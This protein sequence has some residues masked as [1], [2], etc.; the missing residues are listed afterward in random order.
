MIAVMAS[1]GCLT[2]HFELDELAE[3]LQRSRE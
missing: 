3:S 2:K 1:V